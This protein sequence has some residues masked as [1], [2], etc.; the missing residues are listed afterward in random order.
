[1][2]TLYA[3]IDNNV[4]LVSTSSPANAGDLVTQTVSLSG[5]LPLY[6]LSEQ[7]RTLNETLSASIRSGQPSNQL[8]IVQIS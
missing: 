4:V 8:L 7:I 5:P 1:M 2:Q 3:Y 6:W